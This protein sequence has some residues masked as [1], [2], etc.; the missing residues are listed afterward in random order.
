MWN[1]TRGRI[2][3]WSAALSCGIAAACGKVASRPEGAAKTATA[4]VAARSSA[5][6]GDVLR[7]SAVPPAE[8]V[9]SLEPTGEGGSGGDRIAVMLGPTELCVGSTLVTRSVEAM[10]TGARGA[11]LRS[12]LDTATVHLDVLPPYGSGAAAFAGSAALAGQPAAVYAITPLVLIAAYES[13][14]DAGAP[15][16]RYIRRDK[17]GR[18]AVDAMLRRETE[19][20]GK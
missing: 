16:I 2:G 12:R 6:R 13:C 4:N 7:P 3:W 1:A 18:V 5:C 9:W 14:L 20:R 17:R 19:S 8:G 11:E 15:A 10:E